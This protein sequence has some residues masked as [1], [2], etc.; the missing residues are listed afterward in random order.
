MSRIDALRQLL[1]EM[2]DDAFTRYALAME[3]RAADRREEAMV[4][5]RLLIE[6]SP[7]YTASYL[8]AGQCAED[9]GDLAEAARIFRLG[10]AACTGAGDAHASQKCA[11]ALADLEG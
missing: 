4:E 6:R 8:M 5:F 2:P 10:V 9:L 7:D 11:E 3:L 1:S